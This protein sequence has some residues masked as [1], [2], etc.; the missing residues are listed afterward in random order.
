MTIYGKVFTGFGLIFFKILL[1]YLKYKK[2]LFI[3]I[4]AL[5]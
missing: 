5:R 3:I 2:T 1:R 4:D